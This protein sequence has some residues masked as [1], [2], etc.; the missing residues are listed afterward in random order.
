M[1]KIIYMKADYEPWW[2]FDGWE[3]NIVTTDVYETEDD[4]RE[5][6]EKKLTTFHSKYPN[7]ETKDEIYYA[8]WSDEERE[9]CEACDDD[10]QIYHGLIIDKK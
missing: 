6:I 8:F 7:M 10:I 4:F 2:Q 5:A 1:Y 9:Y 3:E